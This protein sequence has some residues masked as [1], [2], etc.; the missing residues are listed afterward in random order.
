MVYVF[1][2]EQLAPIKLSS[3]KDFLRRLQFFRMH[4]IEF[5]WGLVYSCNFHFIKLLK[6][7][8]VADLAKNPFLWMVQMLLE[9]LLP[10]CV[11]KVQV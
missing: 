1:S 4:Q 8:S 9:A 6:H 7:S 11:P 5:I 3:G 10:T 2:L